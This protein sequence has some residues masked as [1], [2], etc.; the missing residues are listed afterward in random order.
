MDGWKRRR[1]EV[2][3]MDGRFFITIFGK[4]RFA[5][6]SESAL[7]DGRESFIRL[8]LFG[9]DGGIEIEMWWTLLSFPEDRGSCFVDILRLPFF[10]FVMF[11]TFSSSSLMS[12]LLSPLGF[13]LCY[14]LL[15]IH[16]L[17]LDSTAFFPLSLFCVIPVLVNIF[18][19][20]FSSPCPYF[21]VF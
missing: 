18:F 6:N 14:F 19:S 11:T 7:T 5:G 10:H 9:V 17:S 12:F 8:L 1:K 3:R 4:R 21:F 2:I 20:A 15:P 16:K 13:S